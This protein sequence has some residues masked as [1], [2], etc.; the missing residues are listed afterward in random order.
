MKF[1]HIRQITKN[2]L[3][4]F[5][6]LKIIMHF[7]S[8][9]QWKDDQY[10]NKHIECRPLKFSLQ[11]K[12]YTWNGCLIWIFSKPSRSNSKTLKNIFREKQ[13]AYKFYNIPQFCILHCKESSVQLYPYR[14]FSFSWWC[15]LC[16]SIKYFLKFLGILNIS[17]KKRHH[18]A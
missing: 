5:K 14:V 18:I 17:I 11:N 2:S 4:T 7:S 3:Q 1:S 16:S 12:A 13:R 10:V 15:H 6:N 9:S 8:K